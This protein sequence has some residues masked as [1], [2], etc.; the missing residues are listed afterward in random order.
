MRR[1]L[2][3]L[4]LT[5]QSELLLNV[6]PFPPFSAALGSI[7]RMYILALVVEVC[8]N[9]ACFQSSKF[10]ILIRFF[11]SARIFTVL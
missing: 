2:I 9:D 8:S 3:E 4:N 5:S 11:G 6:P 1:P 7:C 10:I